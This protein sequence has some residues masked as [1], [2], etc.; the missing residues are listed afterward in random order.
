MNKS[1]FETIVVM[2]ANKNKEISQLAEVLFIFI[3]RKTNFSKTRSKFS[4]RNLTSWSFILLTKSR[5]TSV[6]LKRSRWSSLPLCC[7][8][9]ISS[10][11]SSRRTASSRRRSRS[12]LKNTKEWTKNQ[13]KNN[14]SID[15]NKINSS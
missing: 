6:H 15:K 2:H 4:W 7:S 11:S 1:E 3:F 12:Q 9:P 5:K 8:R 14:D 10:N 13:T